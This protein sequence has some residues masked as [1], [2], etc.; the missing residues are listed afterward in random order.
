MDVDTYQRHAERAI[1]PAFQ[2]RARARVID[3]SVI[4]RDV[5]I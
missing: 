3:N 5:T 4:R 2:R 1:S